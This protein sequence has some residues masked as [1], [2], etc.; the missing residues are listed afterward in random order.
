MKVTGPSSGVTDA[1]APDPADAARAERSGEADPAQAAPGA[2]RAA[3]PGAPDP[4]TADIAA[5]LRAGK[6]TPAAALERVV[7]RVIDRQLGA[8]APAAV[9][10]KLRAALYDTLHGDPTDPFLADKLRRL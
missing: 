10:E 2:G 3:G 8:E 7:E 9:R 6:L 4:L 5:D 1:A